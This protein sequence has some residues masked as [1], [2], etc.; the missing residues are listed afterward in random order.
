MGSITKIFIYLV[1]VA[2]IFAIVF[3][4]GRFLITG[5]LLSHNE[6]PHIVVAEALAEDHGAHAPAPKPV[7]DITTYVPDPIKGK[8]IAALCAACH[9][10][11]AGGPNRTGP[12]LWAIFNA[13]ILHAD[14]FGYS[15]AFRDKK[16]QIT[17]NKETLNTFLENPKAYIPGT[18]MS[19]S[20]ISKEKD[21]ADIIAYLETLHDE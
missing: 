16:G 20:G 4:G 21:R 2:D 10:F 8:R 6:H 17:W 9:S 13:P 3:F 15:S 12:N 7:F 5:S 1:V 11:N 14:S 19:F 18:K